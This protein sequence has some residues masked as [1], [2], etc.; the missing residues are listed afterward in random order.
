MDNQ[1]SKNN[2][3]TFE[4]IVNENSSPA[5]TNLPVGTVVKLNKSKNST[6]EKVKDLNDETASQSSSE[7]LSKPKRLW[8]VVF[9]IAALLILLVATLWFIKPGSHKN[10]A[11]QVKKDIPLLRYTS[12]EKGWNAF[13]P[14]S[15][16]STSFTEANRNIFEG[17]VRF[18][19]KS[20]I[21]PLL[22][23]GWQNPDDKT[24]IFALKSN[25]K[26]HS[27][28]TMTAQ[29]VKDSFEE[30]KTSNYGE[31]DAA[32]IKS[33]EV[34]DP[35]HVKITTDGPDPLLLNKLTTYYVFDTKSGKKNDPYNGTGPFN[36][37]P[38]TVA[39]DT[40]LHLIAFD[41]YHGGHVYVRA[42]DFTYINEQ[43]A[44]LYEADKV[45]FANAFGENIS[46]LKRPNA[47]LQIE[48]LSTFILGIN[49]NRISSPLHNLKV[50]QAIQIG[51]NPIALEDIRKE[52]GNDANQLIP[53]GIPGYNTAISK[54]E[55][56]ETKA[57]SLLAEAGFG[58]GFTITLTYYAPS[59]ATA[60]EFQRQFK[61]IGITLKLDPQTET[62]ILAQKAFNGGTDMFFT[63][64]S[65]DYT[66]SSDI[67]SIYTSGVNY[68]NP[69]IDDLLKQAATTLDTSARTKLLEQASTISAEDVSVI[70]IYNASNLHAIYNPSYVVQ[71]DVPGLELGVYFGKVYA[72]Y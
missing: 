21:V 22:A 4:A 69:K 31:I 52:H 8:P 9:S 2:E 11:Y 26:F 29:D 59:E 18:E 39:E 15:D 13:Y 35:T 72:K 67:F 51:I 28:R 68:R 46:S 19:N 10:I 24:W 60:K 25:V 12:K 34:L 66:D 61:N 17:L 42:L 33:I 23:T 16:N 58:K 53:P 1:P 36:I 27:G 37:K 54:I 7:Q 44:E 47:V 55:H 48:P 38:G 40:S 64:P 6:T 49:I 14:G 50:R 20:K 30:A 5:S 32:T 57:R 62:K 70:P 43:T 71:K 56:D 65:S 45:D 3:Q 63:T 41:A